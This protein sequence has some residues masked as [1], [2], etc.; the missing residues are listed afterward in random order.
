MRGSLWWEEY[1]TT[2][3]LLLYA[4]RST[5]FTRRLIFTISRDQRGCPC[6]A[7]RLIVLG[8]IL[9]SKL[10]RLHIQI[11][12][13]ITQVCAPFE[14][15]PNNKRNW[16]SKHPDLTVASG[17]GHLC[18]APRIELKLQIEAWTA[19]NISAFY[20]FPEVLG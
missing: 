7:L 3:D 17:L 15:V 8:K 9:D 10:D 4:S 2:E 18:A 1:E 6:L 13:G 14:I 11:A 16:K 5:G 20:E 19:G 12:A